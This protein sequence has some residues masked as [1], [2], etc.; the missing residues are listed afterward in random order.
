ME[1]VLFKIRLSRI[2]AATLV[3]SA[4]SVLGA[5]YQGLFRNPM[6]S[7]DILIKKVTLCVPIVYA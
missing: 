7:P 2:L 6:V 4:L 5:A 3:C 1:T